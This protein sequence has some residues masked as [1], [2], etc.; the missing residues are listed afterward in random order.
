MNKIDNYFNNR[1]QRS[2]DA[3]REGM[4]LIKSDEDLR[5][6]VVEWACSRNMDPWDH[7][8]VKLIELDSNLNYTPL[9]V[10]ELLTTKKWIDLPLKRREY[11]RPRITSAPF[12]VLRDELGFVENQSLHSKN[13]NPPWANDWITDGN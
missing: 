1:L 13:F 8:W 2:W 3:C 6:R 10:E 12:C 11:W 7:F 9:H 5:C 4:R